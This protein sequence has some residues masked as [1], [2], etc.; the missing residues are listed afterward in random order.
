MGVSEK[1]RLA[2]VAAVVAIARQPGNVDRKIPALADRGCEKWAGRWWHR[3]RRND[4]WRGDGKGRE[5]RRG[6]TTTTGRR[7]RRNRR[8]WR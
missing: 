4:Q 3:R 6:R 7:T 8:R 1:K 2:A 5:G